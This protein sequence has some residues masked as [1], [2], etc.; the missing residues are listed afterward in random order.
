MEG[1]EARKLVE[2]A[3]RHSGLTPRQLFDGASERIGYTTYLTW[4]DTGCIPLWMEFYLR[5]VLN[6]ATPKATN[7]LC[8][9]CGGCPSGACQPTLSAPVAVMGLD[10]DELI[11]LESDAQAA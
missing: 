4:V 10:R 7:L 11:D 2:D 3:A 5:G 1:A 6:Q 8:H 9:N